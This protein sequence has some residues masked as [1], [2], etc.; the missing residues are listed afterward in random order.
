MKRISTL[1]IFIFLF[2]ISACAGADVKAT[3]SASSQIAPDFTLAD[4]NGKLWK[5][6]DAVKD[7]RAVVLAF[8]PKDDTG[9]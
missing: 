3:P 5:F 2:I 9:V 7:Y 8:Y 1:F 4:Q 6:S